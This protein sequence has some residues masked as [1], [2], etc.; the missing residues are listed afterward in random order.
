MASIIR[1]ANRAGIDM[2]TTV[3]QAARMV[4]GSINAASAGIRTLEIKAEE[5][6]DATAYTVAG[7]REENIARTVVEL[8]NDH[9]DFL[10]E[11]F[12]KYDPNG[13]FPYK[14]VYDETFARIEAAVR[15]ER[16]TPVLTVEQ[17]FRT[18][19]QNQPSLVA[20]Q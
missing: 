3:G 10:K 20:A 8:T 16:N 9:V 11:A 18:A 1:S 4:G 15:G 5:L 2:F 12:E 7:R 17:I 13:T 14:Q 6:A 19:E